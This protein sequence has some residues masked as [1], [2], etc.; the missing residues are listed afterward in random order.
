MA[1]RRFFV[2]QVRA[3]HAQIQGDEAHH[4][5]RVLRVEAGQKYEITDNSDVYLAEIET[6]RKDLVT[7]SVIEKIGALPQ[8]AAVGAGQHIP[9]GG[10]GSSAHFFID[11]QPRPAPAD[12]PLTEFTAVTAGYLAAMNIELVRG[13]LISEQDGPQSPR[14]V[15]VNET[16]AQRYWPQQSRHSDPLGRRIRLE[17]GSGVWMTIVGV[18]RDVRDSRLTRD[19]GPEVFVPFAQHVDGRLGDPNLVVR[20]SG[21]P[22]A[23]VSAIREVVRELDKN[24]PVEFGTMDALVADSVAQQRFQMR[25][26]AL[27]AGLALTLAAVG[28]YGVIAYSV[29]RRTHEIGIRMALGA[30]RT[31]VMRMVVAQGA[32]MAAAGIVIGVAGAVALSRVLA[33]QLYEVSVTDAPTYVVVSLLLLVVALA[34]TYIPARRATTVDPM[35]ALRYE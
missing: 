22:N 31:D 5:T 25:L 21:D 8:V 4:L 35:I 7:F 34:A 12:V 15:V 13:R 6:A 16:M 11:G 18:V 32:G 2:D 26:L 10:S 9:F 24:V 14:V 30:E 27:F 17:P 23:L 3:G 19:P 29:S 20:A 1:R 28:I 33:S